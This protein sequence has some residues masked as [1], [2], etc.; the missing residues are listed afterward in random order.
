MK[1]FKRVFS[2][3]IAIILLGLIYFFMFYFPKL[4]IATAYV[5]KKVCSCHFV[6]NTDLE[7]IEKEDLNL[8][9][10]GY[11]QYEVNESERTVSASLLG[12]HKAKAA[13]KN[14]LGCSLI[15]GEDDHNIHF[16]ADRSIVQ[17]LPDSLPW[18][19]GSKEARHSGYQID[20]DKI[21]TAFQ[22]AFDKPGE[23]E[24]QTRA[25]LVI[26][27]DSLVR[28]QYSE[29]YDADAPMLGWSMTKSIAGTL[30]GI[31]IKEGRLS[32]DDNALFDSWTDNRADI[33]LRDLLQMSSGLEWA[34]VYDDISN[35]T[36]M[37]YDSESVVEVAKSTPVSQKP[38][39][40]WNYSSGTSNLLSGLMR[41]Q[42]DQLQNYQAFP[43]KA[44]FD[45]LNMS[46]AQLECDEAGNYVMSSYGFATARDWAKLGQLYL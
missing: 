1:S 5:A 24:K 34:E 21:N 6:G 37:L 14:D 12:M 3:L 42:F 18:P 46:S 43:Y 36:R 22:K 27:N 28:E 26:H 40:S 20:Q 7:R 4:N 8:F 33:T 15:I 17:Y 41:D 29:G 35:A 44:L 31:M 11:I 38:G 45:K 10:L 32:L 2:I 23:W 16:M 25:L 9:P 19:Y 13:F 30:I 39:T